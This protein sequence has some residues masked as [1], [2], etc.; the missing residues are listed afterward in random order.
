[1]SKMTPQEVQSF[2]EQGRQNGK[3]DLQI[4]V[5]LRNN[6]KAK[7]NF[8][9]ANKAGMSNEQIA[10]SLKL[11][12]SPKADKVQYDKPT[13]K[14]R[15]GAGMDNMFS[16]MKQGALYAKDKVTGGNSYDE[17][18][19][20]KA[21][22]KAHYQD[23]KKQS[24][25]SGIDVAET[26]GEIVATAPVALAGRGYQGAKFL[27]T[28]GAKITAQNAGLGAVGAGVGF[29]ENADKR[30]NKMT[31]GAITAPV[32][33]YVGEKLLGKPIAKM[34]TRH[35]VTDDVAKTAVNKGLTKEGL[36]LDDLPSDVADDLV[37]QA[38]TALKAGR[39][40][41]DDVVG[42]VGLMRKHGFNPTRGQATRR[43][44]DW[45]AEREVAKYSDE[46]RGKFDDDN[47]GLVQ[48]LD[49]LTTATGGMK[50]GDKGV[51]DIG[52][53]TQ[54]LETAQ[55]KIAQNKARANHAYDVAERSSANN[56]VVNADD[57]V[58]DVY[59]SL[60]KFADEMLPSDVKQLL[61]KV[62]KDGMNIGESQEL[63]RHFNDAYKGS[64]NN[65]QPT[66]YTHALQQVRKSLEK[67]QQQAIDDAGGA[68]AD[69]WNNARTIYKQNRQ[70]IDSMP[71]LRDAEKG[72]QADKLMQKHIINGNSDE[73]KRTMSFLETE[74]PQ[75]LA[76]V[77]Q[78]VMEHIA[79]KAVNANGG[80]NP[81]AYAD[82]IK[83]LRSDRLEAIFGADMAKQMKETGRVAHYL[84]QN[85]A[86]ATTNGSNTAWGVVQ[87]LNGML[88]R[89]SFGFADLDKVISYTGTKKALHPDLYDPTKPITYT[90]SGQNAMRGMA[91]MGV[92]AGVANADE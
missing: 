65:G 92:G 14:E 31:V 21:D 11:N 53:N 24:G 80:F 3:T 6:P 82:A 16:G 41:D 67:Y 9:N 5:D 77:R 26:L 19:Q 90:A 39:T 30:M 52:V 76:D 38:K 17:Y 56:I 75:L 4:Y 46:L 71:L 87:V 62:K 45:G 68:S 85:V 57:F 10:Q 1:M 84:Q 20:A 47:A 59:S 34:M 58:D 61:R 37:K 33:G 60:G 51:A 7:G 63:I 36:K 79:G 49:D 81:K 69:A 91:K 66:M 8:V 74:N 70:L 48:M 15:F 43:A 23:A 29:A 13:F 89:T 40:L 54:L 83:G 42:R 35:S 22:E 27:S 25:F 86:G 50:A 32:A 78:S 73:L 55:N 88:K 64:L 18:T 12:V 28:Q 2:I 72:V 44:D